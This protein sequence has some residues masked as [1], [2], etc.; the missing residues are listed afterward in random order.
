MVVV[1]VVVA[2]VSA[3]GVVDGTGVM[4]AAAVRAPPL[5]SPSASWVPD[6]EA[7]SH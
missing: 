4:V 6:D 3:V 1:K 7:W 5:R 2:S